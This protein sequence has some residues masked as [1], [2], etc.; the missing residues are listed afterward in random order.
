MHLAYVSLPS[1]LLEVASEVVLMVLIAMYG[2][3]EKPKQ[4]YFIC[5][6]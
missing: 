6:K 4:C 1:R 5:F 2:R 3:E